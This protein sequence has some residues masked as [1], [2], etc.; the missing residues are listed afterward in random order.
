LTRLDPNRDR[1]ARV[2]LNAHLRSARSA[3]AALESALLALDRRR[4]GEALDA[5]LTASERLAAMQPELE[6]VNNEVEAL[7]SDRPEP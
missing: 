7:V 2:A 1:P 4:P 3:V 6:Q 5:L